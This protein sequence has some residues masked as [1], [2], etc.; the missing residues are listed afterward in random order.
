MTGAPAYISVVKPGTFPLILRN[1][2]YPAIVLNCTIML[3]VLALIPL[4]RVLEGENV[5]SILA[6]VV[7]VLL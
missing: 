5:L 2:H 1:L 7:S 4:H 6:E 3:L